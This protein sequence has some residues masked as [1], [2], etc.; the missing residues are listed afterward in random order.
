MATQ[1][2][3]ID[4]HADGTLK[5]SRPFTERQRDLSGGQILWDAS[6]CPVAFLVVTRLRHGTTP[7]TE[8]FTH[9][10]VPTALAILSRLPC[11]DFLNMYRDL[12]RLSTF[13]S[14]SLIATALAPGL[15]LTFRFAQRAYRTHRNIAEGGEHSLILGVGESHRQAKRRFHP[16]ISQTGGSDLIIASRLHFAS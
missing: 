11:R 5:P 8:A 15:I 12:N 4:R 14:I 2:R 13:R 1:E 3:T 9:G 7:P 16:L 6:L 10:V